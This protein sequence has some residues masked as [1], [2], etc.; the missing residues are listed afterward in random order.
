A[1]T[2]KELDE[3]PGRALGEASLDWRATAEKR[4]DFDEPGRWKGKAAN[5]ARLPSRKRNAIKSPLRGQGATTFSGPVQGAVGA[6]N[7]L[8]IG[9][10]WIARLDRKAV[11]S[12][13]VATGGESER[14]DGARQCESRKRGAHPTSTVIDRTN[15]PRWTRWQL[16][17]SQM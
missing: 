2:H 14:E 3:P 13:H 11:K 16:A 4:R 6:H 10:H 15:L 9:E 1:R 17:R 5:D 12:F 7:Q 8:A